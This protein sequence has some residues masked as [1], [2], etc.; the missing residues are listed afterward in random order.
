MMRGVEGVV[1]AVLTRLQDGMP[2][3]L[4]DLRDR[5]GVADNSLEDITRWLDHEP[6]DIAIDKPPMVVVTELT[7][8]TVDGPMRVTGDGGGGSVYVLRYRVTVFAWARGRTYDTTTRNRRRYAL[9]VRELL[10][11]APGLGP[12]QDPGAIRL[13]PES[14]VETY[15]EVARDGQTREII[16]GTALAVAYDSE[17]Y[18]EALLPPLGVMES[19]PLPNY[20]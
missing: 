12:T 15:S 7:S 17:E 18:L 9:A 8:D 19:V 13:R 3:K 14:L 20:P 11:Q 10:L 5:Y 6:D 1:G 4:A 16:A 2:G